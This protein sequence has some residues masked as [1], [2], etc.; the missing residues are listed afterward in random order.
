MYFAYGHNTDTKE[1]KKRIPSAR[2]VGIASL[3][4]YKLSLHRWAGIEKSKG[5]V[6]TGVVWHFPREFIS[7][8]DWYEGLGNEYTKKKHKVF[9]ENGETINV[10]AYEQ[11]IKPAEP[12]TAQYIGWLRKGYKE[13]GIPQQQLNDALSS[14]NPGKKNRKKA[15]RR[16]SYF[17]RG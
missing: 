10:F 7:D 12:P 5:S 1:F 17:R 6:V 9:G 8:L 16:K 15:T 13:H 11:Q 4:D 14:L 2:Y 3:P